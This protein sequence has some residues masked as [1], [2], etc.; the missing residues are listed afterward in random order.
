MVARAS[1]TTC[2]QCCTASMWN[3]AINTIFLMVRKED[4]PSCVVEKQLIADVV[5]SLFS[6][7]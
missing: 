7:C 1:T 3:R 5:F 6:S 4:V 2:K